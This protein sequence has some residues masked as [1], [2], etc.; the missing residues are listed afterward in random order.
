M[1][2]SDFFAKLNLIKRKGVAI[3]KNDIDDIGALIFD[4]GEIQPAPRISVVHQF[5][6]AVGEVFEAVVASDNDGISMFA[7]SAKFASSLANIVIEFSYRLL[8]SQKN[9]NYSCFSS[10]HSYELVAFLIFNMVERS[11]SLTAMIQTMNAQL[12]LN[13]IIA[14]AKI[15]GADY[16]F[17]TQVKYYVSC[18][19]TWIPSI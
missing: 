8:K 11:K 1:S 13:L 19:W 7:S 18:C 17:G 16:S 4:F 5:L 10:H 9:S 14:L 3:K 15:L 6:V 12:L 2:E